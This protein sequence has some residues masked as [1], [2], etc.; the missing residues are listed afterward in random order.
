M[1]NTIRGRQSI[2]GNILDEALNNPNIW[3]LPNTW[4]KMR[5]IF[6]VITGKYLGWTRCTTMD[7]SDGTPRGHAV[8]L[9]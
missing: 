8:I 4:A 1:L 6:H 5:E 3:R 2:N 7:K 9:I